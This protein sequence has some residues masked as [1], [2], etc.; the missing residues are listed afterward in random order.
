MSCEW[1]TRTV[2]DD[3]EVGQREQLLSVQCV[4]KV[5]LVSKQKLRFVIGGIVK[6]LV[7]F[8][9]R[10]AWQICNNLVYSSSSDNFVFQVFILIQSSP[11]STLILISSPKGRHNS[12]F[13]S[14]GTSGEAVRVCWYTWLFTTSD[15]PI[16]IGLLYLYSHYM[17]V[18]ALLERRKN[19]LTINKRPT[20]YGPDLY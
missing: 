1:Y 10:D 3:K 8:K 7:G 2:L 5:A 13:R 15:P 19:D 6:P 20:L 4:M 11:K 12:K 9:D 18:R 17:W 14:V 16:F